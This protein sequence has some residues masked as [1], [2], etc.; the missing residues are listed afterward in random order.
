MSPIKRGIDNLWAIF[1][2]SETD[3][4]ICESIITDDIVF[5]YLMNCFHI[6][7]RQENNL[8]GRIFYDMNAIAFILKIRKGIFVIISM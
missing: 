1:D 8:Y 2:L 7:A 3:R 4:K 6:N 5:K